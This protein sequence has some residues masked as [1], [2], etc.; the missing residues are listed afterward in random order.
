ML[1]FVSCQS[2]KNDYVAFLYR[3]MP[4]SDSVDYSRDYWERQVA[5]SQKARQEMPWGKI[6]P[7]TEWCHFV[8]PVRVKIGRAHV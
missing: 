7:E 3:Y 6:V 8:V 1:F 4:A 2:E 5:M